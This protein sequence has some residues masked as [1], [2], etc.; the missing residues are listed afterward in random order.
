MDDKSAASVDSSRAYNPW[1]GF[2]LDRDGLQKL[3]LSVKTLDFAKV[4]ALYGMSQEIYMGVKH[5]RF[6]SCMLNT[7][8]NEHL[9]NKLPTVHYDPSKFDFQLALMISRPSPWFIDLVILD[10]HFRNT[11]YCYFPKRHKTFRKMKVQT[12]LSE[13]NSSYAYDIT[14]HI[15]LLCGEQSVNYEYID[16]IKS[17]DDEP[18]ARGKDFILTFPDAECLIDAMSVTVRPYISDN[19][20]KWLSVGLVLIPIY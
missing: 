7:I 20:Y 11:L 4:R 1:L 19:C 9:Q 13:F 2:F 3:L 14:I 5:E 15:N 12:N 6:G 8:K 10:E 16:L 17:R 18:I